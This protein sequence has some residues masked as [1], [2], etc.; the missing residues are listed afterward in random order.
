MR[1]LKLS[2]ADYKKKKSN[3]ELHLRQIDYMVIQRLERLCDLLYLSYG[4]TVTVINSALINSVLSV[5]LCPIYPR[6]EG[7]STEGM[8]GP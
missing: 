5:K 7:S 4:K 8:M 3:T 6:A 1:S 2:V